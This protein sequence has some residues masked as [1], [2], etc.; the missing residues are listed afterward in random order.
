M[1]TWTVLTLA[2]KVLLYLSTAG[3]VGGLFCLWLLKPHALD[4][5]IRRYLLAAGTLGLLATA[6]SFVVHTGASIGEG[7]AGAFDRDIAAIIWQTG[8]GDSTRTRLLGFIVVLA[9]IL[10]PGRCPGFLRYALV[11]AGAAGLL[12]AFTQTGHLHDNSRGKVLLVIH[13]FGISLWLG[14]LYPLWRISDGQRVAQLQASMHRFGQTAVAFVGALMICGVL[15]TLLLVQPLS[16][17]IA[18]PYGWLLLVKLSLV[19]LLL[20]M[21]AMN[22]L[23]LVPRLARPGYPARLRASIGAEMATG[24]AIL[25]VTG[26]LTTATGPM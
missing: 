12:F 7:I 22:K 4:R 13:L 3:I 19:S 26:Y 25:L 17:L 16:G 23:Y 2:T 5:H 9:G 14:S 15:M 8:V 20:A 21:A 24:L 6:G 11:I 18:T 1:D 10:L